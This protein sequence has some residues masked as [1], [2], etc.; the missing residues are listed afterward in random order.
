MLKSKLKFPAKRQ[1]VSAFSLQP[2]AFACA[3]FTMVEIAISLAII[4]FALVAIIGVL[5]I[6]MNVQKDNR[7]E[8]II[9][10]EASVL[11]DA[12]R[13]NAQGM[14]DLTNYVTAITNAMTKYEYPKLNVLDRATYGYTVTNSSIDNAPMSPS[15][16]L[17]TGYRIVGLLSTPKY[18][19]WATSS[20][21]GYYSNHVTAYVRSMSGPAYEK[22]PQNNPSVQDLAFSYRVTC[23]VV[24]YG[25][26]YYDPSWVSSDTNRFGQ[27]ELA[28]HS[29]YWSVVNNLNANLHDV[30]LTFRWP[31]R[32]QGQL[33]PGGQAFRALVGGQ[34]F[35]T[36]ETNYPASLEYSNY[37]FQSRTYVKA[38]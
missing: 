11:L 32:S 1:K 30:R 35:S 13:N 10:Q 17:N 26:N 15:F 36:I 22:F 12:I 23:E 33:G 14:D 5:P 3:G 6:G 16:P 19:P 8:T 29:N 24:P 27:A 18:V 31:L 25:T 34:L 7:E 20:S 2:S 4:G 38:P 21:S 9:N 37:F 28:A